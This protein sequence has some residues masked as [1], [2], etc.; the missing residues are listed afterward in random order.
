MEKRREQNKNRYGTIPA[1]LLSR[2][3]D[4]LKTIF[5][6]MWS[7]SALRRLTASRCAAKWQFTKQTIR[8]YTL[9]LKPT[10]PCLNIC[11]QV[12]VINWRSLEKKKKKISR[13]SAINW[14]NG[15]A[16]VLNFC[17]TK[18]SIQDYTFLLS[19]RSRAFR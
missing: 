14:K 3:D 16:K 8:S 5:R 1:A 9:I 19:L 13:S 18:I 6:Y 12:N 4:R 2:F 15:F 11:S 7:K 10:P 17:Q